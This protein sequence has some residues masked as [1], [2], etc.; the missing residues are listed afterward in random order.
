MTALSGMFS[1]HSLS[2]VNNIKTSL[3]NAQKGNKTV[4][5]YFA[6]MRGFADELVAAGKPLQDDELISYIMHDVDMDY[7]PL[8]SALDAHQPS[9][10]R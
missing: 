1:S 3:V 6:E 7:Q 8:V 10:P 9:I 4:A 2:H 5:T